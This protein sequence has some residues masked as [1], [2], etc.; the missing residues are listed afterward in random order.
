MNTIYLLFSQLRGRKL[1]KIFNKLIGSVC[2]STAQTNLKFSNDEKQYV[3]ET[4]GKVVKFVS[5]LIKSRKS[6]FRRKTLQLCT[7]ICI[8]NVNV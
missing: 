6:S 7:Y 1:S 8:L 5:Q 2:K 4:R 3:C